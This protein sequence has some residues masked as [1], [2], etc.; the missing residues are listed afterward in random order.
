MDQTVAPVALHEEIL[1]HAREGTI[2]AMEEAW[3]KLVESPPTDS[4][5]Y[6]RWTGLMTKADEMK[7]AH[8][9]LVMLLEELANREEWNVL[10]GIIQAVVTHWP[11]SPEMRGLSERA[12]RAQHAANP[13]L[14][15]M[16]AA[17]KIKDG[18]PLDQALKRFRA[19]LRLTP[20]RV[21]QHKSWGEGVIRSSDLLAGKITLD[22][23]TEK[24][25][26]MTLEGVKNF[27]VYLPPDHYLAR[28]ATEPEKL[29]AL[30]EENPSALI[31]VALKS[32][33]GKLI[34]SDL[35]QLLIGKVVPESGW[36][37]WWNRARHELRMD[38]M[39]DFDPKG[40]AR[41]EIAS[42]ER[43]KTF[44]E[45]ISD[46]FFA[47]DADLESKIAAFQKLTQ[48][49][50]SFTPPRALLQKMLKNLDQSYKLEGQIAP[51][52]KLEYAYLCEDLRKLNGDLK[53]EAITIP[54][55]DE[56][57]RT[58]TDYAALNEMNQADYALRALKTLMARDGAKGTEEATR[59]LPRASA[60]L[61]Q[62]IWRELDEEHHLDLA[63]TAME[64][65]FAQ[66]LE[67]P[68]TYL[69][70]MKAILEGNWNHLEDYFPLSRVVPELLDG[71]ESWKDIA[72]SSRSS[73]AHVASA[74]QLTAKVRALL[75]ARHFAPICVA[76]EKM[77]LEEAQSLRRSIKTHSALNEA[78]KSTADRQL[79][80]TRKDLE[81]A[82]VAEVAADFHYCTAR[83]R[84]EKLREL[85]QLNGV[86]IPANSREIEEARQE[87]DLRENA[88]YHAAKDKQKM[89]MQ[90]SL[91]LQQALATARVFNAASVRTDTI[92]FGVRFEAEKLNN[93]E[94]ETYTVLGRWEADP[95]RHILSYQAPLV[96]QFL[97]KKAGD[98]ILVKHP[99]GGETAYRVLSLSNALE[100]GEW[101]TAEETE[102][103]ATTS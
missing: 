98:E 51:G 102:K 59:I 14:E 81:A 85:Q 96:Q 86:E 94:R 63:A 78:F 18:L 34:Q 43:P 36:N 55:A 25:K 15:A 101:E 62:A 20:G 1:S 19:C 45:E 21:Y 37:S 10:S 8:A 28:R 23:P 56:I 60:K 50:K 83:A 75:Q 54:S 82:P 92:G 44:E 67:N 24:G 31:K 65:L 64:K 35:K 57:A 90:K 6:A 87:G 74:K 9:L 95:D 68:D 76:A 32:S 29:Q 26:T 69:W 33:G 97:G 73:P 53:N 5:F 17:S 49:Q 84:L 12:L 103:A 72:E 22:F 13:S 91:Q 30:G 71:L 48:A 40:G 79:V 3:L 47:S 2:E 77:S 16:I 93:G 52:Q 42:R 39:I 38:P 4:E 100:S 7:T 89:L 61:A 46:L 27:L 66:P 70:A 80:L 88:G 11:Q 41:A 58:I 99:G